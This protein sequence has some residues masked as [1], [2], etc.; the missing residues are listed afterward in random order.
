VCG[1][2]GDF[3]GLFISFMGIITD[4]WV[5]ALDSEVKQQIGEQFVFQIFIIHEGCLEIK[6]GTNSKFT[7]RKGDAFFVPS[8]TSYTINNEVCF[9]ASDNRQDPEVDSW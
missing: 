1:G 8:Q 4:T 6:I 9:T 3:E 7:V 2:I 5:F